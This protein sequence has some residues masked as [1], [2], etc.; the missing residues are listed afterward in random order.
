MTRM[1]DQTDMPV[2]TR[3][4]SS[5]RS[6]NGMQQYGQGM[7]LKRCSLLSWE[8]NEKVSSTPVKATRS[9]TLANCEAALAL[10]IQDTSAQFG[11]AASW[12]PDHC[13]SKTRRQ[14]A[15]DRAAVLSRYNHQYGRWR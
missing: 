6:P 12:P 11:R 5:P 7:L 15:E 10:A 4:I 9:Q 1:Y 8:T 3:I 2:Q 14:V 13:G